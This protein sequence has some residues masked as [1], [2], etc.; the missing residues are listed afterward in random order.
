MAGK[1]GEMRGNGYETGLNNRKT[2]EKRGKTKRKERKRREMG[3]KEENTE[4]P[5]VKRGTRVK[6]CSVLVHIFENCCYFVKGTKFREF[7]SFWG[8]PQNS[9]PAKQKYLATH[10]I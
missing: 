3:C 10:E 9:I 2:M 6:T 8:L 1:R 5:G 4:K 7:R